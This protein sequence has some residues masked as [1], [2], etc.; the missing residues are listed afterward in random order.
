MI[1]F[2]IFTHSCAIRITWKQYSISV[3]NVSYCLYPLA[4]ISKILYKSSHIIDFQQAVTSGLRAKDR[5]NQKK[6]YEV[7]TW[8]A[9]IIML[10]SLVV[11]FIVR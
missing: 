9:I 6:L 7:M 4:C 5:L 1:F 11:L 2:L 10:P 3:E 8:I